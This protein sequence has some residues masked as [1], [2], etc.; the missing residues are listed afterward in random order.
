MRDCLIGLG[1]G[2]RH[3]VSEYDL[4]RSAPLPHILGNASAE[5]FL[6][7]IGDDRKPV[8]IQRGV[9]A[10]LP[11]ADPVL[12]RVLL[13]VEGNAP[14]LQILFEI[15]QQR[16][17][18]VDKDHI[19]ICFVKEATQLRQL[20]GCALRQVCLAEE[21]ALRVKGQKQ[22]AVFGNRVFGQIQILNLIARVFDDPQEFAVFGSA[23]LGCKRLA[24]VHRDSADRRFRP[25][26]RDDRLRELLFGVVRP[27]LFVA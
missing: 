21:V 2:D 10:H 15:G 3:G 20:G 25:R 14:L 1:I 24:V 18:R 4:R 19:G 11:V 8:R 16:R 5:R 27:R 12:V 9:R 17:V 7:V 23:R 26:N 13:T 6:L 22:A